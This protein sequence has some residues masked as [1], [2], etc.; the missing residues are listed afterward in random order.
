MF[1]NSRQNVVSR[2]ESLNVVNIPWKCQIF[3]IIFY[4]NYNE[5]QKS[6]L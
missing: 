6:K 2:L 5:K 1:M 4:S 3:T